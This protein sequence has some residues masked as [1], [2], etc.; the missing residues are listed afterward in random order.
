MSPLEESAHRENEGKDGERKEGGRGDEGRRYGQER[1]LDVGR[2]R[3]R[4]EIK[5]LSLLVPH[6][7]CERSIPSEGMRVG[8]AE[9]RNEERIR[10]VICIQNRT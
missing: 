10:Q 1:E 7:Q 3:W 8:E 2:K 5:K 6:C 4:E 9:K